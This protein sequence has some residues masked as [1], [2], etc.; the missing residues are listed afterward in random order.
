MKT[1]TLRAV[2]IL[3]LSVSAAVAQ[4]TWTPLSG[5]TFSSSLCPADGSGGSVLPSGSPYPYRTSG[6]Q[7]ANT[8][9]T[10]TLFTWTGGIA[11]TK[12]GS[13]EM[14]LL[15]GGGHADYGGNESYKLN[16]HSGTPVFTRVG[17]PSTIT[18]N[19]YNTSARKYSDG[20]PSSRH[21]YDQTTYVPWLDKF[22]LQSGAT[23]GL[24]VTYRDGWFYDPNVDPSAA[25]PW[26]EVIPSTAA[27]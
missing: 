19:D 16:L 27:G 18:A 17:D 8:N 4:T 15:D 13:E 6:G 2:G 20:K 12:A 11:R 10:G 22:Y 3:C 14:W 7:G 9:C 5:T 1:L 23:Y 21:T 25:N 24:G 26:T